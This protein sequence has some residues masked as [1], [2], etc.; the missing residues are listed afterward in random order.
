MKKQFKIEG[1]GIFYT[2]DPEV[3]KSDAR[4]DMSGT[5]IFDSKQEFEEFKKS[6]SDLFEEYLTDTPVAISTYEEM[7][8]NAPTEYD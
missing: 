5:L 6:L 8:D 3:G 4:W 7:A 2:G 1:I